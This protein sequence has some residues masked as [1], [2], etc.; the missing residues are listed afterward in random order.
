MYIFIFSI[1]IYIVLRIYRAINQKPADLYLEDFKCLME[2]KSIESDKQLKCTCGCNQIIMP[3]EIYH[4]FLGGTIKY[5]HEMKGFSLSHKKEVTFVFGGDIDLD[6]TQLDLELSNLFSF[7]CYPKTS[8]D[9]SK[10]IN[11][12]QQA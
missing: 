6:E 10:I 8:I 12:L 4:E 9:N 3:E 11:S 7:K 2:C 5:G 1:S